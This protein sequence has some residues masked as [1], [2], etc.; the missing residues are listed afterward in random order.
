MKMRESYSM[1]QGI[2]NIYNRKI[3]EK[4]MYNRCKIFTTE[5]YRL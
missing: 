4:I 5:E 2:R 3:V 1:K